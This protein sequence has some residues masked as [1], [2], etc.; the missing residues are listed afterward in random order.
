MTETEAKDLL[1]GLD[2]FMNNTNQMIA[3][4]KLKVDNLQIDVD[5][6]NKNYKNNGKRLISV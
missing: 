6:L 1:E 5:K 3:Q 4:L 2:K